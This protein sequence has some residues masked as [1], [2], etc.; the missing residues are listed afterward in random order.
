M[1]PQLDAET[2]DQSPALEMPVNR[3]VVDRLF[4]AGVIDDRGRQEALRLM[5]GP[6]VWWPWIDKALLFLGLTLALVGIVCFFAWNWD[7][8]PGI[9]KLG[10]VQLGIV[11]CCGVALWK[12]LESAIGKAAQIGASVLVGVFLAVFGQVYQ[13]GA[14]EW[15]LF[16]AWAGLILPWTMLARFDVLWVLWL[17]VVNVALCLCWDQALS[18]EV[19]WEFLPLTLALVNGSFLGL[20]EYGRTR[21]LNWLRHVWPRQL[22]V[23]AVLIP[24]VTPVIALI[25][26]FGRADGV[27]WLSAVIFVGVV[28]VT[29]FYYRYRT[30]DLFALSCCVASVCVVVTVLAGKILFEIL[31]DAI[32]LVLV[33]GVIIGVVTVA[34]KWLMYV[35]R[36]FRE[37]G[38]QEAV[39]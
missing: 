22:L 12:G 20:Q 37:A 31:E 24:L 5:N 27:T 25:M 14:D 35:A 18:A 6:V 29:Q 26:D 38:H 32:V 21:G 30:P 2:P 9:A 28:G 23:P 7:D 15:V 34:A 36:Q 33:G 17:A 8:L 10:L 4:R 11:T 16:A 1:D 19:S 39:E 13:T 3:S